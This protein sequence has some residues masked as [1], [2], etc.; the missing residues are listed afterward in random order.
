MK[1]K[2]FDQQVY[3]LCMRIPSGRVMTY[4]SI[5]AHI[6]P[7]ADMNPISYD[8]IKARWVG[9]ALKRCPAEVPW[10]RV[11]NARGEISRRPGFELQRALLEEE[12]VNFKPNGSIDLKRYGWKP[13]STDDG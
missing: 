1:G 5:G 9:Y 6:P 7:P 2:E 12:G 13:T 10:H 11:V 8:R 4:G 3:E